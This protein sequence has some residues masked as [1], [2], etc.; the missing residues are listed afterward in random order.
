MTE[1][2]FP[3]WAGRTDGSGPEHARWHSTV[4]PVDNTEQGFALLGFVSDEGVIR[5]QGGVGAA[6]GPGA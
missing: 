2:A 3:T 5:N 6:E 1:F 4:K